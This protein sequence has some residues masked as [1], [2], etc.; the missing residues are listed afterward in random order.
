MP[1]TVNASKRQEWDE[2]SLQS[3][4]DFS[5]QVT[6][7][8]QRHYGDDQLQGDWFFIPEE[9]LPPMKGVD[10]GTQKP[11]ERAI[12]FGSF[13]NDNSPGA[14]EYT[15]AEI[16]DMDDPEEAEE[17]E[18]RRKEWESAEE[19]IDEPDEEEDNTEAVEECYYH[20]PDHCHGGLWECQTCHET[21][22]DEGHWHETT[23]GKNV[24]C[25]SCERTRLDAKKN[26]KS[27]K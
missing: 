14:D 9:P 15:N 19:Y 5:D 16:F 27:K 12:Y 4:G 26:K 20:D 24:E 22:C 7:C 8:N 1:F 11:N 25:V 18:S 17:F 2:N 13:G 23:K 10:Y 21:Y 3:Y 6:E